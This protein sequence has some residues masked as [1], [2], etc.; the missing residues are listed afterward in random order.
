[1][2]PEASADGFTVRSPSFR[3]DIEIEA[4]LI[5]EIARVHGYENIPDDRTSGKLAML[6]LPETRRSRA[7]IYRKMAERGFQE[8]VS[9]AFV[10]EDWERDF[11]ANPSPVRLQNPLAAQYS[12]M[13]STLIGGLI[14]ILQ[15]NLNRKQSRVRVFEIA[16]IFR[17][18]TAHGQP[19]RIGAL[20]YGS[21]LPEQ[22]GAAARAAD[23]YD[24]KADVE[25]LLAGKTAEFVRTEHPALHPGRSAEIRVDG[26]AVG[27]IG[28]LH[29]KWLQKYDLPQAALVFELDM[30]A[31]LAC[32]KVRYQAVSKFQPARRD[33][34]FVL[35]E[36]VS[37]AELEG[38]LKTVR[39]PLIREIALF[40]VYRGKGLPENAKSMAVKIILQS[41]SETLTDEAVEPIVAKLIAA[42][43]GV[44]AKLR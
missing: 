41:D 33:L 32:E 35:P 22:W 44:G 11:A 20:V 29:P 7:A 21:A 16:R 31:V 1:M 4:D 38:S 13:R 3:F 26:A 39:S 14:E 42:A 5:E 27:F 8:V 43:E 25:S 18:E 37:Y 34:A 9:Y 36:G 19:E 10:N 23:F 24:V 30:A 6:T 17:D 40:D 12:V 28:E 2:Q 15:N